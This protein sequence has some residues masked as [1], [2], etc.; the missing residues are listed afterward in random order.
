MR[1]TLEL[2]Y[3]VSLR[4]WRV[5]K[6]Y[7]WSNILPTF[8][9]PCFF[10]LSL[11]VGLGSYV[12]E[13]GGLTYAEFM[14]PGLATGAALFTAFFDSSY[15]FYVRYQMD[16]IYK[17]LLTTPIGPREIIFGELM[18]VSAKGAC[19]ATAVSLVFMLFG[20]LQFTPNILFV[21][22]I[23]CTV[24]MGCGALGLIASSMIQNI[25]QFQTVYTLLISPLFFFS[26]IFFPIDKLPLWVQKVAHISPV[27]H[28]VVLNQQI[29]W[30]RIDSL[31]FLM[32]FAE[33]LFINVILIAIAYKKLYKK[34]YI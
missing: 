32:H 17:A 33:L 34:L 14:G 29:L 4:H 12:S 7:F 3:L 20:I 16:G 27:Y 11:G 31:D 13:M 22:F 28:G 24:A 15:G 1:N 18:W 6:K 2:S 26:G 30:G 10:I 9:E 8:M 5:Y 19:M 21:P 25:S 23:G